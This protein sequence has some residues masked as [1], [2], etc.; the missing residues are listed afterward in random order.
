MKIRRQE[1]SARNV[2]SG[3]WKATDENYRRETCGCMQLATKRPVKAYKC[4]II[5]HKRAVACEA[6]DESLKTII[7]GPKRAVV[8]EAPG[9]RRALDKSYRPETRELRAF[10]YEAACKSLQVRDYRPETRSCILRRRRK[11]VE[12]NDRPQRWSWPYE[13]A[14]KQL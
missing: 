3:R 9:R 7:I 12:K 1:S 13:A 11:C 2:R 4:R 14:Y 5:D 10:G 6:A 8:Y